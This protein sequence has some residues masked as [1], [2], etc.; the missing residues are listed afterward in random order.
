MR[1][2]LVDDLDAPLAR[3]QPAAQLVDHHRPGGSGSEHEQAL[4]HDLQ[5]RAS[6]AQRR[7]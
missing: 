7:A 2:I 5:W 6:P 3:V 4:H 1:R